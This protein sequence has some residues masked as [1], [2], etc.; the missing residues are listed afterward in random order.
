ML[1]VCAWCRRWLGGSV[2]SRVTSHGVC[3]DC[4][5]DQLTEAGV[6]SRRQLDALWRDVG[7]EG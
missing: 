4:A 2:Y 5:D 3:P 6:L 7:G 1:Q